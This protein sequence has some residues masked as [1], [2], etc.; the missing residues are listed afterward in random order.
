MGIWAQGPQRLR[1]RSLSN[2]SDPL[3][4]S[5]ARSNSNQPKGLRSYFAWQQ[6]LLGFS[7]TGTLV[8]DGIYVWISGPVAG[9]GP[10]HTMRE[11]NTQLAY[12]RIANVES[13]DR[14]VRFEYN[15]EDFCGNGISLWLADAAA[16]AAPVRLL[17]KL[18]TNDFKPQHSAITT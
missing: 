15:A 2:S 17:P 1:Q 10:F 16:A 9:A 11:E 6:N 3:V 14:V 8:A 12:A 5:S 13:S 4:L 7:G 18:R